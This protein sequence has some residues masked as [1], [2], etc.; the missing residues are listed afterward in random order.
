MAVLVRVGETNA[1]AVFELE[2]PRALDLQEKELDRIGGPAD[3]RRLEGLAAS[4]DLGPRVIGDEAPAIDAA[5]QTEVA[6]LGRNVAEIDHDQ[7][8]GHAED[9]KAVDGVARAAATQHRLV[10]AGNGAGVAGLAAHD[11][12]GREAAFK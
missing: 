12:V 2:L 6:R 5:A 10:I 11:S 4:I 8:V 1:V 7:V 9:R 3:D